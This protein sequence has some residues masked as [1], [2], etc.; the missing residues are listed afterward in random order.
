MPTYE[1]ECRRCGHIF[2]LFTSMLDEK[3]KRCPKCRGIG[4]KL[5]GRGAGFIFK[6]SGFYSTDYRSESYRKE[7]EREKGPLKEKKSEKKMKSDK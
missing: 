2:E 4:K 6:G 1:Y 5:P 7:K 3:E